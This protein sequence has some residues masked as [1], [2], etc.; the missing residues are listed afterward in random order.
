MRN[1]NVERRKPN[2]TQEK[3]NKSMGWRRKTGGSTDVV[4]RGRRKSRK[5]NRNCGE[6]K[7][8][9]NKRKGQKLIQGQR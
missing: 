3:V 5:K 6:K 8:N 1:T 2:K 7:T 9:G 4:V